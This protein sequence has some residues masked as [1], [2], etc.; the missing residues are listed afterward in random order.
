MFSAL[1][2][3]PLIYVLAPLSQAV[4]FPRRLAMLMALG[5]ALLAIFQAHATELP[6]GVYSLTPPGKP[7]NAS[8]L[9]NPLV[10]G[11]SVRWQWQNIEP[12][13][14]VYDWS[15]FDREIARVAA[16][17]KKVLLRVVSGGIN[18][19]PWVFDAGVETFS[20]VDPKSGEMQTVPLW[21]DPIFLTKKRNLIAAMGEHFAGHPAVVL[22]SSSCA[23]AT[24]DDWAMPQSEADVANLLAVGY[25]PEKLISAC[26]QIIDATTAAFPSQVTLMAINRGAKGLDPNVDYVAKKVVDYAM[27]RYS[28]RFVAQKNS[29]S[30]RTWDPGTASQLH[31]W[32]VLY[33]NRPMVAGQMLWYVTDDASCRM[34]GKSKPCNPVTVLRQAV[35]VGAHY[36]MLYQEI[37]QKDIL[38]PDLAGV[39]SEAAGLLGQ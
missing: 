22:V 27:T 4:I 16:A 25:T 36:E 21:W 2:C 26:Q 30:A 15:Y 28:G 37:Y 23:N 17:G 11:V 3:R 5:W 34:N 9:A 33:D 12:V 14:G 6:T 18:T 38:N 32:Q 13:E 29:L 19:P 35:T 20:F 8:I 24:S 39:I 31:G 10:A 7:V 1:S